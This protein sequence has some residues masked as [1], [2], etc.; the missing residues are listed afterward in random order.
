MYRITRRS[1]ICVTIA[2]ATVALILLTSATLTISVY[3]ARH[4]HGNRSIEDG[5]QT[6]GLSGPPLS[7]QINAP[8]VSDQ[9]N[10]NGNNPVGNQANAPPVSDQA[11]GKEQIQTHAPAITYKSTSSNDMLM[12]F[13]NVTQPLCGAGICSQ[14]PTNH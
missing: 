1:T 8:P 12:H 14:S 3:A 6:Y 10:G 5:Y 13:A 2:A 4:H 7:D 9:A 11:N